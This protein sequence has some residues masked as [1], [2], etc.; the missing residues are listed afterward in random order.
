MIY[1]IWWLVTNVFLQKPCCRFHYWHICKGFCV[2][3]NDLADT[4]HVFFH[5][6]TYSK[7]SHKHGFG[8][9]YV[10]VHMHPH[11]HSQRHILGPVKHLRWSLQTEHEMRVE[12]WHIVKRQLKWW[13]LGFCI[14]N[15]EQ[16]SYIIIIDVLGN[17]SIMNFFGGQMV[18]G[19]QLTDWCLIGY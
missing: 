7:M 5:N 11:G 8:D 10:H 9:W 3:C 18:S 13:T 1:D 17:L 2:V 16:I 15:L 4:L 19:F 12:N 6:V 14:V